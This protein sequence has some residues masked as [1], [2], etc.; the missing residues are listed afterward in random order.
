MVLEDKV[1]LTSF[2]WQIKAFQKV[3]FNEEDIVP[4]S[5]SENVW[6][7][8]FRSGRPGGSEDGADS[9]S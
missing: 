9:G 6:H 1:T 4:F 2:W 7:R 8:E 5:T 3:G